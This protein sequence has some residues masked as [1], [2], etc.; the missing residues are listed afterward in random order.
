MIKIDSFKWDA[1]IQEQEAMLAHA[2]QQLPSD[3]QSVDCW[4]QDTIGDP[5]L[6]YLYRPKTEILG[7][8]TVSVTGS[9]KYL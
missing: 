6:E 5:K 1:N 2:V 7:N 9:Y 8:E 3:F 4:G